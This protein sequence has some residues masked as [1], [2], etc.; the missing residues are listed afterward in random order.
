MFTVSWNHDFEVHNLI[1]T[2]IATLPTRLCNLVAFLV[3]RTRYILEIFF[4]YIL[5]LY[6]YFTQVSPQE[7]V[8]KRSND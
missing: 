7:L 3:L 2:D 1:E 8:K 5:P 4:A 6:K